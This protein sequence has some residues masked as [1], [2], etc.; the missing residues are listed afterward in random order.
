MS[1]LTDAATR[2]LLVIAIAAIAV[3]TLVPTEAHSMGTAFCILCGRRG[4]A[5]FLCN[6]LLFAPFGFALCISDRSLRWAAL[7]GLSF[8]VLIEAAQLNLVAGRDSNIGDVLANTLGAVAGWFAASS[9]G[10]WLAS[11]VPRR[12]AAGVSAATAVVLVTALVTFMPS[13]PRGEWYMQWTARFGNM[14]HYEGNVLSTTFD[15]LDVPGDSQIE[16]MDSVR[17]L[18]TRAPLHVSATAAL[19]GHLAPIVS[20][21]DGEQREIML[22]GA[23]RTNFVYRYRMIANDLELDHGELRVE[24]AFSGLTAGQPFYLTLNVDRRRWCLEVGQRRECGAGFTVGDTWGLLMSP[25]WPAA[26]IAFMRVFW[27]WLVFL[28]AGLL[29]RSRPAYALTCLAVLPLL[30]VGPLLIG[31]AATPLPQLAA[32]LAGLASG[33]LVAPRLRHQ[34]A[35]LSSVSDIGLKV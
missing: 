6:V 27:I 26:V 11:V 5:D 3:A 29:V 9:R 15:A 8:S 4:L 19:P 2:G 1:S 7:A 12:R 17:H 18:L 23:D 31:F 22:L 28:P 33:A 32:A 21:Y 34:S 24:N 25:D 10:W 13:L 35:S 14:A 16:M 30:L 20:I